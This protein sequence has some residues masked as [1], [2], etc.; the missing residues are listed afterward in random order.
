MPLFCDLDELCVPFATFWRNFG[1]FNRFFDEIRIL[2]FEIFWRNLRFL[3]WSFGK[4]CDRFATFWR[5]MQFFWNFFDEICY[6]FA[7]FLMKFV[8]ISRYFDKIWVLFSISPWNL[9]LFRDRFYETCDYFAIFWQ[10]SVF[11]SYF[12]EFCRFF[13]FIWWIIQLFQGCHGQL[14]L[15]SIRTSVF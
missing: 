8:V 3:L 13:G 6:S 1:F 5:N 9:R 15:Y 11:S 2:F 12:E 4:I 10:N 14:Y 7:T